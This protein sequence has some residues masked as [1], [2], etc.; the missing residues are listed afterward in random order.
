MGGKG[1][2]GSVVITFVTAI[3]NR[4]EQKILT[5]KYDPSGSEKKMAW[6]DERRFFDVDGLRKKD[7]K[8]GEQLT[9]I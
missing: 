9:Q 5:D 4:S 1:E 8:G 7:G 2:E 3:K 6:P